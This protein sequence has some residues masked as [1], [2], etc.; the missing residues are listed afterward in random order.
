VV[1]EFTSIL[2][3][4]PLQIPPAHSSLIIGET[5]HIRALAGLP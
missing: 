2:N 4:N 3:K 1:T 5:P